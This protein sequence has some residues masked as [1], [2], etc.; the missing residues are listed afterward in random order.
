MSRN[1]REEILRRIKTGLQ[2]LDANQEKPPLFSI[3]DGT[4][5]GQMVIEL[6]EELEEKK[7]VWIDRFIDELR[8][9]SGNVIVVKD[10]NEVRESII[11]LIEKHS[12]RSLAIW[13]S[14]LL[15]SLRELL[16]NKGLQFVSSGNKDDMA[17]ADIGITEVDYAIAE[18]GTIVLI[19]NER[20]PRS[21]SLI[22]P[23]H[24]A[25]MKSNTILGNLDELFFLVKNSS[26]PTSCM[27][28]ITGPSRTA[29]I[30]L[31]LTL[32]VHGPKE[33]YVLIYP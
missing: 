26:Q 14:D 27:T 4:K 10:E 29:D 1:S 2:D 13:E 5:I 12:V 9:V 18:T 16:Q 21:V 23:I 11:K 19:A 20:Q 7:W 32:G 33:L 22:P 3:T 17:K 6:R 8:R 25:V 30:E 31:N 28:F 15:L 24:I